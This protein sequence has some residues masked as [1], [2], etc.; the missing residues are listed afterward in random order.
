MG[1]WCL[2]FL[3]GIPTVGGSEV[4]LIYLLK[5]GQHYRSAWHLLDKGRNFGESADL[6]FIIEC[7]GESFEADEDSI[8]HKILGDNA[9]ST[10]E[11]EA[12]SD[13]YP[14]SGAEHA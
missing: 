5:P 6:G 9:V 1:S 3:I 14:F 7:A 4:Q 2:E 12:E 8:S 13:G 11:S 10:K